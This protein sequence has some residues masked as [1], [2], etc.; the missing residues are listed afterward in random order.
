M[1]MAYQQGQDRREVN[2]TETV[3]VK[4]KRWRRMRSGVKDNERYNGDGMGMGVG[5][6][7]GRRWRPLE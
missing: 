1:V 7:M 5:M 2:V 4:M 3:M 6:E